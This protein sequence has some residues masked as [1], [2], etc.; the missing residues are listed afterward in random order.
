MQAVCILVL[1][2]ETWATA[3]HVVSNQE[4]MAHICRNSTF[5]AKPANGT[6]LIGPFSLQLR[7]EYRLTWS[8]NMSS[9]VLRMTMA[10]N[11]S[12]WLGFGLSPTAFL[13]FHG[14]NHADI[15]V[16]TFSP[17]QVRDYFV[18]SNFEVP[19]S[20]DTSLGGHDDVLSYECNYRT[21]QLFDAGWTSATFERKL[22]TGDNATDWQVKEGVSRVII[23]H[24]KPG[25]ARVL[26]YHG[27]G[28]TAT[29]KLNL[30]NGTLS[31]PCKVFWSASTAA[32]QQDDVT[33]TSI[34]SSDP[35]PGEAMLQIVREYTCMA[36]H[37][38]GTE[39]DSYI[40]MWLHTRLGE[41]GFHT[42]TE[43]EYSIGPLF[44]PHNCTVG[45]GAGQIGLCYPIQPAP[46]RARTF[47]RLD[48]EAVHFA[49]GPWL[50]YELTNNGSL[51]DP[52]PGAQVSVL[53]DDWTDIGLSYLLHGYNV[54][55]FRQEMTRTLPRPYDWQYSQFNASGTV[56]VQLPPSAFHAASR[57]STEPL[58]LDLTGECLP[59]A[60][61]RNVVTR[62]RSDSCGADGGKIV[63][64]STPVNGFG[65]GGGERAPGVAILLWLA[66]TLPRILQ[67]GAQEYG[68]VEL[69]LAFLSGHNEGSLG[70]RVF[71]SELKKTHPP[72]NVT[73]YIT[74]GADIANRYSFAGKNYESD[75]EGI[76]TLSPRAVPALWSALQGAVGQT[77]YVKAIEI[78]GSRTAGGGDNRYIWAAGYAMISW[79]GL[80]TPRFHM[81]TDFS[82]TTDAQLL[83]EVGTMV[84]KTIKAALGA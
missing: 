10:T 52:P 4:A 61:S 35:T 28:A 14:M 68:C 23:A 58:V 44:I 64:I 80:L 54:S 37:L 18:N 19:P 5:L 30:F 67:G 20:L 3:N 65:P 51:G 50:H 34:T 15:V 40:R 24:G 36:T 62:W 63:V 48:H 8:I 75:P 2:G 7:P 12:S 17:C 39:Q 70:T 53:D 78:T 59:N 73:A 21:Q 33:P 13:T 84:L 55:N 60:S 77:K 26:S 22:C 45:F 43:Q 9:S 1:L 29:C 49:A 25:E 11:T 42:V 56:A 82:S 47:L 31:E 16:A 41:R 66:E 76:A 6:N 32:K 27:F 83:E 71:L 57:A 74:L 79:Q 81:P 38:T 46:C 69:V 72:E